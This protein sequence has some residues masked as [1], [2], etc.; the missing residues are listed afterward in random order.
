VDQGSIQRLRQQTPAAEEL[1]VLCAFLAPDDIPR[2]LPTSRPNALPEGLA[3]TVRAP[4]A[5][6]QAIGALRR[7]SLITVS[8]DGQALS[9][10]RLV[11]AV[12]RQQVDG[13]Q[14]HQWATAALHL[15]RAA[16]PD[17][18]ADPDAWPGYAQL[19]PHVLAATDHVSAGDT[20]VDE[21]DWLLTEAG[22]YLRQRAEHQEAQ[23]LFERVLAIREAPGRRPP[24]HRDKPAEP[25]G[26]GRSA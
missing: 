23:T 11:Q 13:E 15:L 2:S 9:V 22:L 21:T 12:T 7:Y 26:R 3:A 5:Y 17:R 4:L 20:D 18:H 16:F 8:Q 25:C 1:L 14:E 19:L 24:R 10:H 6:Q